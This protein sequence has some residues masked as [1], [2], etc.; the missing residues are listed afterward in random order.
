MS[1]SL[2]EL[3]KRDLKKMICSFGR[4]EK[5][6][7]YPVIM[8]EIEKILITLVLEETKQNYL[9]ASKLLGISRSTLYRKIEILGLGLSENKE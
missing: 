5:G 1:L 7:I 9:Q 8:Q 6:N 4:N 2:H 3:L